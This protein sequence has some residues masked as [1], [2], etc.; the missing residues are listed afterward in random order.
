M[1]SEY[2]PGVVIH[3]VG[4][5]PADPSTR[6]RLGRVLVTIDDLDA[7]IDI[8]KQEATDP[9]SV[10]IEFSGGYFTEARDIA[11]LSDD[12]I[13]SLKIKSDN[14][15]VNLESSQA[16]AV[17]DGQTTAKIKNMWARMRQT[18]IEPDRGY[19]LSSVIGGAVG[20]LLAGVVCGAGILSAIQGEG[21]AS[22]L[23]IGAVGLGAIAFFLIITIKN[24]RHAQRM[25]GALI[26][27]MTMQEFRQLQQNN[28]YPRL[29]WI[30]AVV[31]TII[32][33]IAIV[34]SAI[35]AK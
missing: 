23:L 16:M 32:A 8:L 34:V 21:S 6:E 29:S 22:P 15:E 11:Q 14:A 30:W 33:A 2:Y 18:T 28:R 1:P 26:K 31:A 27:P 19:V 4:P 25:P 7:L 20:I 35:T 3:R 5:A 17:G 12:E 13:V 9:T 24:V 10:L